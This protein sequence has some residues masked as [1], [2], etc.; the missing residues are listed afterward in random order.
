M[1]A[2]FKS[3]V[4]HQADKHQESVIPHCTI[5]HASRRGHADLFL[6]GQQTVPFFMPLPLLITSHIAEAAVEAE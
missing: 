6:V 1:L 5:C 4:L 2:L 3:C